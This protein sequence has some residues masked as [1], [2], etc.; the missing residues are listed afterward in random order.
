MP[1]EKLYPVTV[2]AGNVI[3]V[4]LGL[5]LVFLLRR[6]FGSC[7]RD[8]LGTICRQISGDG[9]P[10]SSDFADGSRQMHSIVCLECWPKTP[11]FNTRWWTAQSSR[12]TVMDRAQKG[13]SKPGHWAISAGAIPV[14]K[15]C[16]DPAE[17]AQVKQLLHMRHLAFS[18]PAPDVGV[19]CCRS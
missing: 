15:L 9:T 11:A 10:S 19:G 2:L 7:E 17:S 14:Q 4:A 3:P 8:A 12:S 16:I 18:C 13:D 6:F 1:N 5:T